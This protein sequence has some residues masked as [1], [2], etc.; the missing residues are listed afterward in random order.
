M[1]RLLLASAIITSMA[2]CAQAEEAATNTAA[3]K[4]AAGGRAERGEELKKL[5]DDLKLTP[6]QQPKFKEAYT[7]SMQKM[8]EAREKNQG[9]AGNREEGRK[10]M[11]EIG[12]ALA[13]KMKEILT[14]EQY[15]KWEAARDAQ[16]A[17]FRE[18]AKGQGAAKPDAAAK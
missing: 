3:G 4:G 15:P 5:A 8:K 2:L 18:R 12:D 9:A 17:K 1:K 6:E 16:R 10:A 14:P 11:K 7:E 13:A